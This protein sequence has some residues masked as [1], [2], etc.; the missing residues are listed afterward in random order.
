M[1][2][3]E[4]DDD[5]DRPSRR[6]RYR[7][8]DDDD[9]V[10][11]DEDN[12]GDSAPGNG[13]AVT[14]M[15]LGI[16]GFCV[17]LICGLLAMLFGFLG[18]A[19][20]KETG[21]G[22]G[23]AIAGIILGFLNGIVEPAA[24]GYGIYW[25]GKQA[26]KAADKIQADIDAETKRW[27]EDA[28]AR[29]KQWDDDQKELARKNAENQK[30]WDEEQ[31]LAAA[32]REAEQLKRQ[33][34]S[35]LNN[36]L[37]KAQ[38]QMQI[39]E[40]ACKS[41]MFP[42]KAPPATLRDLLNPPTGKARITEAALTDPW[43]K[44]Y[45]YDP[46]AKTVNGDPDPI[47]F[48]MHPRDNVRIYAFGRKKPEERNQAEE[49]A[50]AR[51]AKLEEDKKKQEDDPKLIAEIAIARQQISV[52]EKACQTYTIRNRGKPPATLQALFTP[53][54]GAP[55]VNDTTSFK[56]PWGKDYLYDA[57]AKNLVGGVDPTVYA[58]H[59]KTGARILSINRK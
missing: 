11:G 16:V 49:E 1:P 33:E 50:K 22:K 19:R 25:T 43:G 42:K 2:R 44:E 26:K 34:E 27:E 37:F 38:Q 45:Q 17:P 10:D 53:P 54:N 9:S 8:E 31:K 23:M 14:S 21:T 6:R 51:A 47:V 48:T 59:P 58:L 46:S 56:D 4:D 57:D 3:Y 18:L 32:K 24:I 40:G 5:D 39:L 13:F 12:S 28:K 36:D 29:Q 41:Y 55:L 30:K 35:K 15:I 20:S 52:L 7:D